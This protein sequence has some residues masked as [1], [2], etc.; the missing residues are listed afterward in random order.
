MEILHE[1]GLQDSEG[2]M[3]GLCFPWLKSPNKELSFKTKLICHLGLKIRDLFMGGVGGGVVKSDAIATFK[4][5]HCTALK[6]R[7]N[8]N[9]WD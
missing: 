4:R 3:Q 7:A 9:K 6:E 8:A 2:H 5:Q 1:L